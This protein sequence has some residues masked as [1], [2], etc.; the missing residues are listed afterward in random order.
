MADVVD[1]VFGRRCYHVQRR[2]ARDPGCLRRGPN[3]R[4]NFI[5]QESR[6]V[7]RIPYQP[8]RLPSRYREDPR[9]GTTQ[10]AVG[11]CH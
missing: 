3:H 6:S 10:E 9:H 2:Q 11:S 7:L 8:I 1:D 5:L 4:Y